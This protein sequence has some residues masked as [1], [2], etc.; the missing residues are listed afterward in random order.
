MRERVSCVTITFFTLIHPTTSIY[1][2][3]HTPSV[4]AAAHLRPRSKTFEEYEKDTDDV[5]DDNE[6]DMST[7]AQLEFP[8]PPDGSGKGEGG[9]VVSARGK[10]AGSN[11]KGISECV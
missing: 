1:S 11:G 10:Q 8:T 7:P 5:W 6:E 3:M 9:G 4:A 2:H